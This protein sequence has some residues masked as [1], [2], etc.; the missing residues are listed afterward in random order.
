MRYRIDPHKGVGDELRRIAVETLDEAIRLLDGLADADVDGSID[1][2]HRTRK[3]CKETRGLVRL[4]RRAIGDEEYAA[5][6]ALVRDAARELSELRDSQVV[7]ATVARL[8][9]HADDNDRIVL[10]ELYSDVSHTGL[11]ASRIDAADPQV[12]RARKLLKKARK[13]ARRW[14][15][16]DDV[17][18][19]IE[20][21]VRTHRQGAK[22]LGLLLNEG[23]DEHSHEWRKR[24]KHLWYQTRL[25]QASAPPMLDP[26]IAIADDCAEALGDDHDLAVLV[27]LL[28]EAEGPRGNL[29]DASCD[30]AAAV[31]RRRQDELRHHALRLGLVLYAESSPSLGERLGA[32]WALAAADAAEAGTSAEAPARARKVDNGPND[33]DAV[34]AGVAEDAA[35][36]P[37]SEC[38]VPTS[39]V[40]CE[41]KFLV[42]SDTIVDE[43]GEGVALEQG[44][45]ALDGSTSV[46]V[47]R[48]GGTE[49]VLTLKSGTGATR[50]E[51]E[52]AVDDAQFAALWPLTE[53]RRLVK[54]RHD[55]AVGTFI[56][57][58]DVF[59]DGLEGLRLVEVEFDDDPTMQAFV[60][61][62]WF[63]REVTDDGRYTNAALAADGRPPVD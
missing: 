16:G 25:L 5:V 34:P 44:Y 56:A 55:V 11:A 1:R 13:R 41:R 42:A 40:E 36:Q 39:T 57:T 43:V 23:D 48:I 38:E 3:R 4:S 24:V 17:T 8:I 18:P 7:M 58:L 45:V 28:A 51:V 21:V 50:T 27:E 30:R 47:R 14:E 12:R 37:E 61:P 59:G 29:G 63:G 9:D 31:A 32:Y 15:P 20:G 6:D 19:L 60:P 35:A 22:A 52:W 53:G 33:T 46:R 49:G 26:V 54:T 10:H 62:P 2:V